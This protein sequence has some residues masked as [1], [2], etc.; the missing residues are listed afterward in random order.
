MPKK[1]NITIVGAGIGGLGA[2]IALAKK[3]HKVTVF[4]AA[5]KLNEVG[6][7]IQIPPNSSRV[8][9]G[10]GLRQELEDTVT[11]PVNIMVRRYCTGDVIAATP[12]D[13]SFREK[14]GFPYWLIHRADYQKLLYEVAITNVGA[15]GIKSK[16]RHSIAGRIEPL[17]SPNCAFRA[18]VPAEDIKK[19]PV[20]AALL[21]DANANCWIGPG[22][23]IMGYQIRKGAMYN[24]VMSHPGKGEAGRWSEPGNLDEMKAQFA[25]W[26]ARLTRVLESI[27]DV[28]KWKLADLPPLPKWVSRNVVLI[29][30]AAHAMVPYL[31]Q[32]AAQS[33]E[34]GACLAECLERA[35]QLEDIPAL[36]RAFE[37]IRK[38][39]CETVQKGARSNGDVWHLPDGPAQEL[40][41]RNWKRT[42]EEMRIAAERDGQD[43]NRW[44]DPEFQ[45]WLFGY[46]IVKEVW[47]ANT[48]NSL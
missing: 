9:C 44:N 39:R 27:S 41:D 3:G 8:V 20:M 32:G 11:S 29:G 22:R 17:D 18:T 15:D 31:A 23:H 38:P 30:D 21:S 42:P 45:P 13:A 6:A 4:E 14:Y 2:A 16:V 36:L 25:G 34:D 47:Y 48:Q 5:I 43:S 19:D 40:R 10:Y 26:E 28:L 7:G 12:L 33:I 46:D 35:E 1:F 24:V 37:A